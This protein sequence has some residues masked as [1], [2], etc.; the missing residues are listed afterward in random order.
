[1]KEEEAISGLEAIPTPRLAEEGPL[2][3]AETLSLLVNKY[4]TKFLPIV[5]PSKLSRF[6]FCVCVPYFPTIK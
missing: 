2:C 5:T 6:F 4:E 3:R 1:M